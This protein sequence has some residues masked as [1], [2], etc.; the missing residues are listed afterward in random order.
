MVSEDMG[1]INPNGVAQESSLVV[2]HESASGGDAKEHGNYRESG[3]KEL[4][5]KGSVTE[6]GELKEGSG[7]SREDLNIIDH[8]TVSTIIVPQRKPPSE[9]A[10]GSLSPSQERDKEDVVT[11]SDKEEEVEQ[12][13]LERKHFKKKREEKEKTT[14]EEDVVVNDSEEVEK[15][16]NVSRPSKKRKNSVS[17]EPDSSKKRKKGNNGDFGVSKVGSSVCLPC[18]RASEKEVAIFYDN[19]MYTDDSTLIYLVNEVEFEMD[20]AQLGEIL[21]VP[22][23]RLKIIEGKGSDDFKNLIVKK[24]GLVTGEM[25]FKKQLKPEH[26]LLFELVHKVLLPRIERRCIA[27]IAYMFL[28]EA[29][30]NF[31]SISLPALMIEH[32]IKVVNAREDKHGLPYGFF[33]TKVFEHFDMPTGKTTGHWDI[34]RLQVENAPLMAQLIEKARETSSSGELA[35][36]NAELGAKNDRLKQK[37]DKLRDQIVQGQRTASERINRLF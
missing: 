22:T 24:E 34:E 7:P 8:E 25:L 4:G 5:E 19:L 14:I 31:R 2:M 18:P 17:D 30:V 35:N 21:G 15:E 16:K 27:S 26:Q 13:P 37:I 1:T 20:E 33:L 6:I 29:L 12:A 28:L 36:A 23:D 10:P 11:V 3:G 32:M 9:K